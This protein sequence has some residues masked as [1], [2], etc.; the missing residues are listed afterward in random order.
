MNY[1][2]ALDFFA[3]YGNVSCDVDR[4]R[5]AVPTPAQLTAAVNH[6]INPP[7]DQSR[8]L[9]LAACRAVMDHLKLIE[10]PTTQ[11]LVREDVVNTMIGFWERGETYSFPCT[12][13]EV[14]AAERRWVAENRVC[15]KAPGKFPWELQADGR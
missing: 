5:N 14:T 8:E 11:T 1:E 13:A 6:A 15:K 4:L 2:E 12:K 7:H 10:E 9:A 3:R